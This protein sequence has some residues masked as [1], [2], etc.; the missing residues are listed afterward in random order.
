MHHRS[1]AREE[2]GDIT[3][4]VR[5]PQQER[6]EVHDND[7]DQGGANGSG[8]VPETHV[9]FLQS[10]ASPSTMHHQRSRSRARRWPWVPT[11]WWR[12]PVDRLGTRLSGGPNPV[13]RNGFGGATRRIG[14]RRRSDRLHR[15]GRTAS[16]PSGCRQRPSTACSRLPDRGRLLL[17]M[18]DI[19]AASSPGC[20][21]WRSPSSP[22]LSAHRC[23][24]FS[25]AGSKCDKRGAQTLAG[26]DPAEFRPRRWSR[27]IRFAKSG[28]V[29]GD[30]FVP[31]NR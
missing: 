25:R 1:R 17:L 6:G 13:D 10:P 9:A 18:A 27:F 19:G 7:G 20:P 30:S 3:A 24:P 8:E 29:R 14:G 22:P 23:L 4:R 11:R 12:K 15:P 21:R 28:L 16:G 31:R 5:G 2:R 26:V